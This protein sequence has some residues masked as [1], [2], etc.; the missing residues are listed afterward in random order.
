MRLAKV[1]PAAALVCLPRAARADEPDTA[2]AFFAGASVNVVAVVAGGTAVSTAPS[3]VGGD[4]R[5]SFGWLGIETGFVV[6]PLV[7]HGIVGEWG[8]GLLFS[9]LPV[10][11]V[12]GTAV[13][14]AKRPDSVENS[15]LD[16]QRVAW[17]LFTAAL[18]SSTAGLVDVLTAGDA[19]GSRRAGRRPHGI[20]V[21]PFVAPTMAGLQVQGSL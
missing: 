3:G 4:A 15:S 6:A 9:I 1:L 21:V 14:Y 19:S 18:I 13:M 2:L 5:R 8:R 17:S 12:A 7:A 11:A 10:A 20:G 16:D